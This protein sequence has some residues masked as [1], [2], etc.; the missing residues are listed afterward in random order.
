VTPPRAAL[1]AIIATCAV[2]AV[3]S[4][5]DLRLVT[6]VHGDPLPWNVVFWATTPRWI[7]FAI[8]LP[9]V[10]RV[11]MRHPP[12]PLAR[13]TLLIQVGLF[14]ALTLAHALVHG[15]SI[16]ASVPLS[17]GYGLELRV[18][19]VYIG[20]APVLI[21][22]YAGTLL[23]AWSIEQARERRARALRASQLEAQLQ[24]ARLAA[25]RAQLSPHF[26]YNTL[27]GIATL[28]ADAQNGRAGSALEELAELLHA[29]YRDD[30]REL[31]PLGEEVALASRYLELQQLRFGDRLQHTV[32]LDARAA[33]VVVPPLILQ[34]LVENAVLHGLAGRQ[35]VM[36]LTL[37]VRA[38]ATAV[39]VVIAHDGPV[40]PAHW[41]AVS[42][43]GVGLAN[44][45][46]RLE[47]AFDARATLHVERR[48][49]GGVESRL[50]IAEAL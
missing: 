2:M 19:R 25:L 24:T 42:A 33:G 17:G 8:A 47:T 11:T 40:L 21:P 49:E 38:T 1:L 28:V 3:M 37:E 46:A 30:G 18:V 50:V 23:T 9:L 16:G 48:A 5:A 20:S 4:A 7:L 41:A 14:L 39:S 15:A 43:A 22:L 31:I 13:R 36:R 6:T 27:N 32:Q 44:T 10:L 45:R 34:P 12:W 35:G 29:A 26:L